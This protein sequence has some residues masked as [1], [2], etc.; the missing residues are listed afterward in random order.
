MDP[1]LTQ[2]MLSLN[3]EESRLLRE[4]PI[5]YP[6]KNLYHLYRKQQSK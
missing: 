5:R 1:D 2:K 4:N 6:V 3:D